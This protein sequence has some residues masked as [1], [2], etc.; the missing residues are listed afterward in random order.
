MSDDYF[1]AVSWRQLHTEKHLPVCRLELGT[2]LDLLALSNFLLAIINCIFL[3]LV[4]YLTPHTGHLNTGH[5]ALHFTWHTSPG[6]LHTAHCTL[7]ITYCRFGCRW[8]SRTM[9]RLRHRRKSEPRKCKQKPISV[10]EEEITQGKRSDLFQDFGIVSLPWPLSD[11]ISLFQTW[12]LFSSGWRRR[13]SS[14]QRP[15]PLWP[16]TGPTPAQQVCRGYG[17]DQWQ[18]R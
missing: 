6:T 4:S 18:N 5:R 15:P 11:N 8:S 2:K 13:T 1:V 10:K 12:L 14:R 17:T 9:A 16:G 3:L 7:H